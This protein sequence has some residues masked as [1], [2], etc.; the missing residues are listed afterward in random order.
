MQN[1]YHLPCS[2]YN[3]GIFGPPQAPVCKS[4]HSYAQGC[5]TEF[6]LLMDKLPQNHVQPILF[7]DKLEKQKIDSNDC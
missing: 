6:F 4:Y 5:Y 1:L 7:M 2:I 3:I